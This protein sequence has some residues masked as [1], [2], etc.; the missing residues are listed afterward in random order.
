MDLWSPFQG[1]LII[2]TKTHDRAPLDEWSARRRD[3]YLQHI[4]TTDK[5]P[6]PKWE[7]NI[8]PLSIS[9]KVFTRVTLN[10]AEA[11]IESHLRTEQAGFRKNRSCIDHINTLRFTLE[12]NMETNT[13]LYST[14]IDF[15]QAFGSL[16]HE[17]M[18]K[19]MAKYVVPVNIINLIKIMYEWYS[20]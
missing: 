15:E 3:L 20:C 17:N 13:T 11:A 18:W 12:Q 9:G 6:C 4:N 14:F 10:R 2:H 7:S 1:F 5:H 16:K 19:V 8:S